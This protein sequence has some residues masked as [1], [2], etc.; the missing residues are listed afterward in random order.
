LA[1]FTTC[2]AP[3]QDGGY[4]LIACADD[5][6]KGWRRMPLSSPAIGACDLVAPLAVEAVL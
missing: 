2:T 4:F 5:D 3:T 6:E 1:H